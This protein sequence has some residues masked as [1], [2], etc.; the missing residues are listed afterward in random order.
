MGSVPKLGQ[1]FKGGARK[2]DEIKGIVPSLQ[3]LP[4]GCRFN[5][6]CPLAMRRCRERAPG[7]VRMGGHRRVRCWLAGGEK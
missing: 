5:P 4:D 2:L 3:N 1:K 6:R 7:M